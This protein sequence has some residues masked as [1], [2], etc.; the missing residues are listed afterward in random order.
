[1][2]ISAQMTDAVVLAELGRRLE[3]IRLDRNLSQ[4]RL[5]TEAGVSRQTV[6]RIESGGAAKLPAVIR[7]LRALGMLEALELAV[8]EPLPSPIQ[9]LE[10]KGKQRQRA[11][12]APAHHREDRETGEWSWGTP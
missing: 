5:A 9:Q 6:G 1:M 7:I 4:D 8:P 10:R 11:R 2:K 12:G 3:R